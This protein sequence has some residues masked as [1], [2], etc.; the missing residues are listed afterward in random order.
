M[1]AAATGDVV[2]ETT[3]S[4]KQTTD[5]QVQQ[6]QQQQQQ[7]QQ[8]NNNDSQSPPP[9]APWPSGP[10]DDHRRVLSRKK[11]AA[12]TTAGPSVA[13]PQ[14]VDDEEN[15][16]SG[17]DSRDRDFVFVPLPVAQSSGEDD[18]ADMPDDTTGV[19]VTCWSDAASAL[20]PQQLMKL[21]GLEP[22]EEQLEARFDDPMP[23][24]ARL[25]GRTISTVS[26]YRETMILGGYDMAVSRNL[27]KH[28]GETLSLPNRPDC[29]GSGSLGHE[30][31]VLY[32]KLL[33]EWERSSVGQNYA[34]LLDQFLGPSQVDD[35]GDGAAAKARAKAGFAV[36]GGAGGANICVQPEDDA[37]MT[38]RKRTKRSGPASAAAQKKPRVTPAAAA[39][40]KKPRVTPAAA[41]EE[42]KP[43]PPNSSKGKK[44][45]PAP[46]ENGSMSSFLGWRV[47][48]QFNGKPFHGTVDKFDPKTRWYH[49]TYDDKDEEEFSTQELL[50]IVKMR[51]FLARVRP[52]P[53]DLKKGNRVLG[54]TFSPYASR[55]FAERRQWWAQSSTEPKPPP[56]RI[57]SST[58]RW[59]SEGGQEALNKAV[60]AYLVSI[61]VDIDATNANG[62]PLILPCDATCNPSVEVYRVPED[63]P[64]VGLR[65]EL[66]CRAK[67][68]LATGTVVGVYSG[69]VFANDELYEIPALANHPSV[70]CHPITADADEKL[71]ARLKAEWEA[72]SYTAEFSAY[73]EAR[74][75]ENLSD[76]R[77][78]MVCAL[79]FDGICHRVNDAL[80]NPFSLSTTMHGSYNTEYVEVELD[81]WPFLFVITYKSLD[82][83][84]ELRVSYTS[85]YW[86]LM[87]EL[88]KR[89]DFIQ[90]KFVE[91]K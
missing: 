4:Q 19:R 61:G 10:A 60:A 33:L 44:K 8:N 28:I 50:P 56:L 64:R 81:G 86:R 58:A 83:G 27:W 72:E 53:A 76:K 35:S 69:H 30:V 38:S 71:I 42:K 55:L 20:T 49:V 36:G 74:R 43:P 11:A 40:E 66:G 6:H 54:C 9:E 34:K 68:A 13:L 32:E 25:W 52:V 41:A 39:E 75:H 16:G 31:R 15:D 80:L 3:S 82:A 91:I 87:R 88:R 73:N 29:R 89:V 67:E 22:T 78:L 7:Q 37:R 65:G 5:Q 84:D 1:K 26:M 79:G 48:K 70:L 77:H 24:V 45:Q 59:A 90:G 85:S 23:V 12:K 18:D 63:D 14:R 2:S 47:I 46:A 17:K 57:T 51:Q 62:F 21:S